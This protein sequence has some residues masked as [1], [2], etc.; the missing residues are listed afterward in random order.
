MDYSEYADSCS[1]KSLNAKR[2]ST[3]CTRLFH[4]L[5]LKSQGIK[6]FETLL[7][8]MDPVGIILVYIDEINLHHKVR[9][10]DD[11]RIDSVIFFDEEMV[12]VAHIK[13]EN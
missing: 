7:F 11:P 12:M 1:E 5:L 13:Q 6:T 3:Q 2:A 10:R 9:L 8:D 4:C